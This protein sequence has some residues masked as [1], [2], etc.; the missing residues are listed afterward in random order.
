LTYLDRNHFS[1]DTLL[2]RSAAN[3]ST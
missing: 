3:R 2:G 1:L